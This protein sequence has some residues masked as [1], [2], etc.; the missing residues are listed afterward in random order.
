MSISKLVLPVTESWMALSRRLTT[1]LLKR[2]LRTPAKVT[3]YQPVPGSRLYI[4]ASCLPYHVSGYTTRTQAVLQALQDSGRRVY[5]VTR[6]GYPADR[7][8]RLDDAPGKQTQNGRVVYQHLLHPA[9]NCPVLMYAYK[10]APEI[11]RLAELHGI[12]AIHA[13]SNHVNALPG[14]LAARQ[15][16]IPFQ[17]EM[18]GI[19]E[20]TRISR[21]PEFNNSQAFKQGLQLEALVARNAD[22]VFVI[23]DQ[24]GRYITE[25]W[26]IEPERISLLPN[27]I[28]P[29]NFP[30]QVTEVKITHTIGYA[31]SL[32]GY[33]GLDTL[34]DAVALAQQQGV[35]ISVQIAGEGEARHELEQQCT[36]LGLDEQIRFL[37][38]L[39]PEQAQKVIQHSQLVCIPRKPYQVCEIVPPIKLVEAMALGK[40]V[41][42]PD[43]PVFR[44]ELGAGDVGWFF[45]PGDAADLARVIC[46]A[47]ENRERL[48][49]MGCNAREQAITRRNWERFMDK[50]LQEYTE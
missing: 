21:Q 41:I 5:A 17:Y 48:K 44:D 20:L 50:V 10:A 37:G 32:I 9:N 2:S 4:A 46:L 39:P 14:L 42:V 31:G 40:P 34:I 24:L 13:A 16:G 15:L 27:C 38:R 47:L 35:R 12:E 1:G 3:A 49:D 8:D 33:E 18:R 30:A 43:L 26:G 6:P 19:W 23:S 25:N 45:Q 36:R 22:R 29:E 11:A 28:D 7:K